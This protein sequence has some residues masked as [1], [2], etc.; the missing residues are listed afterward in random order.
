MGFWKIIDHSWIFC[1]NTCERTRFIKFSINS[2]FQFLI[3]RMILNIHNILIFFFWYYYLMW[4]ISLSPIFLNKNFQ[5]RKIASEKDII[6]GGLPKHYLVKHRLPS[7]S[8]HWNPQN[9][10]DRTAIE[11]IGE[12]ICISRFVCSIVAQGLLFTSSHNCPLH[13]RINRRVTVAQ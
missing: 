2:I 11:K 7:F 5:L 1:S 12:R 6:L 10:D 9:C 8:L 3:V 4:N 13:L